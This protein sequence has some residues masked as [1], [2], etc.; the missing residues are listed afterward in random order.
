MLPAVVS[1][2]SII[3]LGAFAYTGPWS[4]FW[5]VMMIPVAIAGIV[6][7]FISA[8]RFDQERAASKKEHISN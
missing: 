1:S 2:I 6:S 7:S 4:A 8:R 5:H 3:A